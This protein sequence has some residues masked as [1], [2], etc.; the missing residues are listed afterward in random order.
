M[1]IKRKLY[2]ACQA[3]IDLRIATID[4]AIVA[5]RDASTDDTKS[6]AGD[7]YETTREM[8][9]QEIDRNTVQLNEAL[10]LKQALA[11]IKPDTLSEIVQPGSLVITNNGSFYL[12]ISAGSLNI[13]GVSYFAVSQASPIGS[14]LMR[15]KKGASFQFNDKNYLINEVY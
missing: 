6:S 7:K 3:Y 15:L 8:M 10:K 9:Q 2:Q 4:K 14:K 11:L 12:S 1:E 13:E 5:A